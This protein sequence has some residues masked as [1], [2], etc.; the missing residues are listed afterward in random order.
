[1]YGVSLYGTCTCVHNSRLGTRSRPFPT[2]QNV[3]NLLIACGASQVCSP[4]F[5]GQLLTTTSGGSIDSVRSSSLQLQ[6]APPAPAPHNVGVR[7]SRHADEL[8][9]LMFYY[10]CQQFRCRTS[11][12]LS[13]MKTTRW[14]SPVA[15]RLHHGLSRCAIRG[16]LSGSGVGL[17]VLSIMC[18]LLGSFG[19]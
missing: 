10:E 5:R 13:R 16:T 15:T 4:A 12:W 18:L 3:H 19:W 8:S 9:R 17:E 2:H 7:L 11:A 6:L 1:M 14:A